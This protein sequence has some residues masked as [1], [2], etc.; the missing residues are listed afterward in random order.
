[1]DSFS[2][3]SLPHRAVC[4]LLLVMGGTRRVPWVDWDE[5]EEVR[6]GLS[7]D[8]VA[9]RDSAIN[10]V[11]DWRR[12]GRVPHAVDCTA[13]LLETRSL[14]PGVPGSNPSTPN[15]SENMLRL[16]YAA[17]IVRMVNG[18]VDPSQ[19]GKYAAPVMTLAKR[20]GIPIVLVDV[21]MAASHNEMPQL[22][23]LRHASERAL[24]WLFER[25]WGAQ[26][27]QLEELRKGARSAALDLVTAEFCRRKK[28][29][30]NTQ[31]ALANRGK[32]DR[33]SR[34]K[35]HGSV[36][37][38]SSDDS[39]DSDDDDDDEDDDADD[40]ERVNTHT[41]AEHNLLRSPKKL[42]QSA[43]NRFFAAAARDD[44]R[45]CVDA[46]MHVGV[47]VARDEV[48]ATAGTRGTATAET[49]RLNTHTSA[50]TKPSFED[51]SLVVKRLRKRWVTLD[52][53]LF[54]A[55]VEAALDR[56]N[57]V[58]GNS[59]VNS[60]DNSDVFA[61]VAT[62]ATQVIADSF[63]FQ[64]NEK[65]EN[66][67]QITERKEKL[68]W[69]MTRRALQLS[70]A[71]MSSAQNQF[72]KALIDTAPGAG[73]T[74]KTAAG[75]LLGEFLGN[76]KS[77]KKV[78][79][80]GVARSAST[81]MDDDD[82]SAFLKAVRAGLA[83]KRKK[84][85]ESEGK[86]K[87]K[88]ARKSLDETKSENK[89]KS[90]PKSYGAFSKVADWTPCAVG[91][92]PKHL[93]SD[94]GAWRVDPGEALQLAVMGSEQID[95]ENGTD[96]TKADLLWGKWP[97][98]KNNFVGF[99][100]G[101]NGVDYSLGAPFVDVTRRVVPGPGCVDVNSGD[102]N[103][104]TTSY[105]T[106]YPYVPD[107]AVVAAGEIASGRSRVGENNYLS[108]SRLATVTSM[109]LVDS[110]QGALSV[111]FMDPDD[112]SDTEPIHGE[113]EAKSYEQT[114]SDANDFDRETS[115]NNDDDSDGGWGYDD[116]VDTTEELKEQG[117]EPQISDDDDDLGVALRVGGVRVKLSEDD[118][119]NVAADVQCLM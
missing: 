76:N 24:Q 48:N 22:T 94:E 38:S 12:R 102:S 96:S 103:N 42:K 75:K 44:I 28:A 4:A 109:P 45:T 107:E 92:L 55:A 37:S 95:G 51:W 83:K 14:D 7:G 16:A 114:V 98:E 25:Y 117:E 11:A 20:L 65:N 21:R 26:K 57:V 56:L 66:E 91:D 19:K 17:A 18:A 116:P 15:V 104:H 32:G 100:F 33:K 99:G 77:D 64:K 79:P 34:G 46:L 71:Q 113:G 6:V 86:G 50:T 2:G 60:Q 41:S 8:D 72:F 88:V 5:W 62:A 85:L 23:L 105:Q 54:L 39:D 93:R 10:R 31:R 97:D 1:M 3:S 61:L 43:T 89:K 110:M 53:E 87:G 36:E 78:S 119:K 106:K 112:D 81:P 108:N 58:D 35:S 29:E 40:N 118:R 101:L 111:V 67:K 90:F 52:E 47:C 27:N 13:S 74:F 115:E 49:Q 80:N 82:D 68:V 63:S 9:A 84:S 59:I 69:F 73:Q 30:A 70:T